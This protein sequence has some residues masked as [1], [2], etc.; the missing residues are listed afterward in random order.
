[1]EIHTKFESV[2]KKRERETYTPRS[3]IILKLI[4]NKEFQRNRS[5]FHQLGADSGNLA[6]NLPISRLVEFYGTNVGLLRFLEQVCYI[7]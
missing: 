4:L 5:R 1:V 3:G 7:V 6:T 2:H